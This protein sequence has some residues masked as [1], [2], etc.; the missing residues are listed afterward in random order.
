MKKPQISVRVAKEHRARMKR[1]VARLTINPVILHLSEAYVDWSG[2]DPSR[3]RLSASELLVRAKERFPHLPLSWAVEG[4]IALLS[5][6][7]VAR[8][9]S[10]D[11][12]PFPVL[13][14]AVRR[15]RKLSP[16]EKIRTGERWKRELRR[17]RRAQ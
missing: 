11:I 15:F 16:S 2:Q 4:Y 1:T 17:L 3:G 9:G 10:S 8:T 6:S 7:K 5:S 14:E 13:P 12:K